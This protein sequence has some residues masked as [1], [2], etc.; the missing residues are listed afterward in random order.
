MDEDELFLIVVALGGAMIGC[1]L[2]AL[3]MIFFY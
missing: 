1:T 2:A 3:V